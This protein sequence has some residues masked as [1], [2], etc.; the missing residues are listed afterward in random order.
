MKNECTS[1]CMTKSF[2]RVESRLRLHVEERRTTVRMSTWIFAPTSNLFRI[3]YAHPIET[4]IASPRNCSHFSRVAPTLQA[5]SK[6][7]VSMLREEFDCE[8]KRVATTVA[9]AT[10]QS[11]QN[12]S[13][14][15]Y[16]GRDVGKPRCC[17]IL[18]VVVVHTRVRGQPA[19]EI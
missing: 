5:H 10:T 15:I 13:H 4:H 19:T 9:H 6:A 14:L 2:R 8:L 11:S 12:R 3:K 18:A 17:H 7:V 16:L 1:F